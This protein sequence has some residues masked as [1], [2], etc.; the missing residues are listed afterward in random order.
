MTQEEI[1]KGNKLI[2]K[3]DGGTLDGPN[4]PYYYFLNK[5]KYEKELLY[6]KSWDWLMPV[7]EK[8]AKIENFNH[9]DGLLKYLVDIQISPTNNSI[10]IKDSYYEYG[11]REFETIEFYEDD[12]IINIFKAIVKFIKWYNDN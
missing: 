5:G 7:V 12:M 10:V 11:N 9:P 8:I 1:I 4:S 2:A 3:F 6:D